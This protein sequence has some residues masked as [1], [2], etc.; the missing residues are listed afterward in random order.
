MIE[1]FAQLAWA[2]F[3][4]R[5]AVDLASGLTW[6]GKRF[7][8]RDPRSN[9]PLSKRNA[10]MSGALENQTVVVIGA[11]SGIGEAVAILAREQG[12]RVIAFSRSGKAPRGV[13]GVAVD[14][15]DSV[16]LAAA[17]RKG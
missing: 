1:D 3:H 6:I 4:E 2:D 11:S 12:A 14:V 5:L 9:D 13:E 10:G 17:F 8:R 16:A 7:R 15:T